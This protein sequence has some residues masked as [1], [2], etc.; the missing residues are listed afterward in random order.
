MYPIFILTA[1][2]ERCH[3]VS[4]LH[5]NSRQREVFRRFPSLIRK[6]PYTFTSSFLL[7]LSN[8]PTAT[9][10][11]FLLMLSN[12]PAATTLPFL[13]MLSNPP[14]ATTLLFLLMLSNPPT[15]TTVFPVPLVLSHLTLLFPL[16]SSHFSSFSLL[17]RP[18]FSFSSF[19][20]SSSSLFHPPREGKIPGSN[21]ACA[22]IF[23]GVES[24]Q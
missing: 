1:A 6:H 14:A 17:F 2:K 20:T 22:G 3:H 4:Y 9:T 13:L 18:L 19:S 11:L 16:F 7:M 5:S 24:Y 8:P 10:L 23:F 21:P 12:P 15:A